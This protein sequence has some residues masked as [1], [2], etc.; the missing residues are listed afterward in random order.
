MDAVHI[1]GRQNSIASGA[2]Q[3]DHN[4]EKELRFQPYPSSAIPRTLDPN[5]LKSSQLAMKQASNH[6]IL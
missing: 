2:Y 1:P 5:T 6:P 4:V 3:L